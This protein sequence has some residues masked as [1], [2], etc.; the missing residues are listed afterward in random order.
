MKI[1]GRYREEKQQAK[2]G[3]ALSWAPKRIA[4]RR[5]GRDPRTKLLRHDC[6][7]VHASASHAAVAAAFSSARHRPPSV[8]P[9][10]ATVRATSP[11]D[12][13]S[14]LDACALNCLSTITSHSTE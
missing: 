10:A 12:R 9:N 13:P 5:Q 11:A 8:L 14:I 3:A 1:A 2:C 4:R 6:A 7:A